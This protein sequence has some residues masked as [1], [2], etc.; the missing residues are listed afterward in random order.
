MSS[1]LVGEDMGGGKRHAAP[2]ILTFPH[3]GGKEYQPLPGPVRYHLWV[4]ISPHRGG[5]ISC[6]RQ[7]RKIPTDT[8]PK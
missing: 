4:S 5:D 2:P 1:P 3:S 6:W 7:R 8:Q